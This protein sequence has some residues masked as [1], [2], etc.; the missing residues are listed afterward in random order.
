MKKSPIFLAFIGHRK[1]FKWKA[2]VEVIIMKKFISILTIMLFF[3]LLP[4]SLVNAQ[5][6][7]KEQ[8]IQYKNQ[9]KEKK[10]II[11]N[12]AAE[13]KK[14]E[15]KIDDRSD[16]L[17]KVIMMLFDRDLPPSDEKLSQIESKQEV[18]LK[19]V[20]KIANIQRNIKRLRKEASINVNEENYKQAM[21]N[22]DKVIVLQG[23][24]K[25]LLLVFDKNLQEF[26]EVI[27][28][29]QYK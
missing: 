2:N 7:T 21:E 9:I 13:N 16:E 1:L 27:K 11:K 26:I 24:E 6:L 18:I 5:E 28:S 22:F 8:K 23:K 12:N 19:N 17:S 10:Q 14:L 29:L 15:L 20:E 25:E 3:T 4:T